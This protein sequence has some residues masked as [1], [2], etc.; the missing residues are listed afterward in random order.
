MNLS[1]VALPILF[2]SSFTLKADTAFESFGILVKQHQ[3]CV[4]GDMEEYMC[5]TAYFRSLIHGNKYGDE[6]WMIYETLVTKTGRRGGLWT[7]FDTY[8]EMSVMEKARL[9]DDYAPLIW[10]QLYLYESKLLPQPVVN[11][12]KWCLELLVEEASYLKQI[13][14]CK[15]LDSLIRE[16]SDRLQAYYMMK[17]SNSQ[18]TKRAFFE[19]I[20][21]RYTP[22]DK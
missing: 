7:K 10:N 18:A 12:L 6:G 14:D 17:R 22:V 11:N 19:A 20:A 21:R 1:F 2:L 8:K 3:G 4:V 9:L 15:L 16:T 5:G 13:E